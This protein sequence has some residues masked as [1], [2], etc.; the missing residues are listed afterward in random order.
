MESGQ[1][2]VDADAVGDEIRRI[3]AQHHA[4]T[5]HLGGEL[6]HE[7]HQGGIGIDIGDQF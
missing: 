4:F 2:T 1:E 3:F 5:R 7:L 6:L